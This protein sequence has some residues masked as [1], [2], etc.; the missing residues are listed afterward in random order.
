[1]ELQTISQV[2]RKYGVSLRMLRYYEKE[3]LL[4]SIRKTDYAYR[5]YDEKSINRLQQIIILRKLRIPVKQ[6][7][8][9]LNNQDATAIIDIFQKSIGELDE[10]I[11]ALSTIRSILKKFVDELRECTNITLH[12]RELDD[13]SLS[14]IDSLSFTKHKV[15]KNS[16]IDALDK[17]SDVV[18]KLHDVRI[19]YL[20]PMTMASIFC[21]SETPEENAW[22]LLSEFMKKSHLLQIKPDL[23]CFILNHT[24]ATGVNFGCEIMVSIPIDFAV[25][26]PLVK[27]TFHGGLYAAQFLGKDVIE[28]FLGMQDWINESDKY[29][30]DLDLTR[31]DPPIKDIDSFGGIQPVLEEVLNIYNLQNPQHERQIDALYP[32]KNYLIVEESEPQEI[33]GSK[34]KC[35]F[36]ASIVA[37]NK[38]KIM[39]FT[40]I[41][42]GDSTVEQFEDE[43]LKDGRLELLNKFRNPNAPLLTYESHDMDS[44]IRGG[45]RYTICLLE[46]DVVDVKEFAK[47]NPYAEK[48]DAS[49]WL[50]FEYTQGDEWDD[51]ATCMKLGYTWN[52][53]ISGS[54]NVYP[55]GKI[56]KPDPNNEAEMN[57]LV[58]C[59]YPIK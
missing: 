57:S 23:R 43:L 1:M 42:S 56:C 47:H 30:F 54:F 7:K 40:K 19:I 20:P 12:L 51:H 25:P 8:T 55:D 33:I 45:W 6:I 58:Y 26:T 22:Q 36:K 24:N 21:T 32:I 9:I 59:W 5:M 44:A 53:V 37:K 29:Q 38:F 14:L 34:E 2:S 39:G 13:S 35:G 49:K 50:I 31:F 17:A 15:K 27:K 16:A 10:E 48:I 46:S 52:G 28:P 3:G 11:T 4:E 18:N 41:M